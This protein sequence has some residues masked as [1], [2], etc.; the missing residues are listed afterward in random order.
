MEYSPKNAILRD[1]TPCI[2]RSPRPEDAEAILDL[3]KQATA[4]TVYLSMYPDEVSM[5]VEEE[6]A[7]L[8]SVCADKQA[9]MLSAFVNGRPVA[10]ANIAPVAPG[11]SKYHHRA[12]FG[13]CVLR[14]HWRRGLGGLLTREL[15]AQ[16]ARMGYEQVELEVDC[17]NGA[18]RALYE[19][20][21]FRE[22][23]VL[24]RAFLLRDGT[25]HDECRMVCRLR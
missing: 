18:A 23:G 11:K 22:Y 10:N 14:A 12:G 19:S 3:M 7:F 24:E 2:L 15:L 20:C 4:E 13:I 25:C 17:E 8:E 6:R 9:L 21:G 16:A 1:G 5:T